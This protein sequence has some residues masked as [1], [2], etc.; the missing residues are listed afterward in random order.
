MGIIYQ[1]INRIDG[2]KYIGATTLPINKIWKHHI[3][4]AMRMSPLLIHKEMGKHK[5][6]NFMHR[7]ICDCNESEFEEKKQYYIKELN[8][9]DIDTEVEETPIIEEPKKPKKLIGFQNPEYRG[10]GKGIGIKLMGW[11]LE[12]GEERYWDSAMDAAEELTG[13]RKNNSNIL[14][15]SRKGIIAYGHRWKMIDKKSG[16]RRVVAINKKTWQ[17]YYFESCADAIRAVGNVKG[18]GLYK[19][20]KSN[21]RKTWHGYIWKYV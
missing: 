1:L 8:G 20:L 4:Q 18:S 5:N 14:S 10:T 13:N 9:I 3:D 19:A 17:E 12:T 21:G 6:H 11:N 15:A 7:E 16:K 2:T